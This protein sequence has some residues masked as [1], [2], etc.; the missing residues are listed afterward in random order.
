MRNKD[1]I[2][3]NKKI[4][5]GVTSGISIYKICSL[6]RMFI[7]NEAK[8]KVIM[9]ENATKLISPLTFEALTHSPVYVDMFDPK[10]ENALLHLVLANWADI[11]IVAPATANTIGK[12]A[13]G[14]GDNLLTTTLLALPKKTPLIVVPAMNVNM[15]ENPFVQENIKK[16][17]KMKNCYILEPEIGIL[18]E[19]IEAKGRM[20]E[21]EE[22]FNFVKKILRK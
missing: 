13:N 21:P 18:A 15:W 4:L 14:L 10:N 17:R 16:L 12:I 9:T 8:V 6:V 19:G 3:K 11:F 1:K 20:K 7:Y 2:L 22:I 5:V